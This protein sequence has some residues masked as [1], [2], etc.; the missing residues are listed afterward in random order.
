[1]NR[2][3]HKHIQ[4]DF[5]VTMMLAAVVGAVSQVA[6]IVMDIGR[7]AGWWH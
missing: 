6:R 4:Q 2:K 7:S 3:D 5:A 1:M